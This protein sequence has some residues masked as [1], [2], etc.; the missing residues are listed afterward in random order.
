M[1]A[2]FLA[3]PPAKIL[4]TPSAKSMPLGDLAKQFPLPWSAYV[5]LL[6]VKSAEARV[7]RTVS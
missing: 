6:S 1:R 4:Q 3:W 2:F 5:R 7:F